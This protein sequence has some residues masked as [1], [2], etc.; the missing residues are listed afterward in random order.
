VIRIR[1]EDGGE[2]SFEGRVQIHPEARVPYHLDLP[3]G[4]PPGPAFERM[5]IFVE[6]GPPDSVKKRHGAHPQ[7]TVAW[8]GGVRTMRKVHLGSQANPSIVWIEEDP[9]PASP[10]P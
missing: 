10:A 2:V 5:L 8:P 9:Q 3:A 1:F 7:V 4:T 6:G